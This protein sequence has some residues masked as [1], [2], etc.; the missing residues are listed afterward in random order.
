MARIISC[1]GEGK[2]HLTKEIK[3]ISTHMR[4]DPGAVEVTLRA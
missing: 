1:G 4:G 2:V 3:K